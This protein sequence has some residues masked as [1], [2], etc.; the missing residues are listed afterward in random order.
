M[1]IWGILNI[2][3]FLIC[4][5]SG[6]IVFMLVGVV[7]IFIGTYLSASKKENDYMEN[8]NINIK[9]SKCLDSICTSEL[10]I[11]NTKGAGSKMQFKV[12]NK[13]DTSLPKGEIILKFST[14]QEVSY[15]Y[16]QLAPKETIEVKKTLKD[17]L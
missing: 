16:E 1:D 3:A 4:L 10:F 2:L 8:V 9:R 13:K 17:N 14:G 12:T 15:K 5:A 11:E 7:T 6:G